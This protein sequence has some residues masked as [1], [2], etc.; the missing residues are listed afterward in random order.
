VSRNNLAMH[1]GQMEVYKHP[2]RFKCVV[3]GRRW[4][5]SILS[6]NM[7]IK[8][9]KIPRRK[10]W[11]VAPTY[12]M[13]QQIMWQ[14][15]LDAVPD[16]WVKK[17]NHTS[18]TI[19]LINGSVIE[20]KGADNPDSLRGVGIHFLVLDEYQDMSEDTWKKALR[21]TL[22]DTG[23]DAL[24]IGTPKSYNLLYD[25]Y[26]LGQDP[27]RQEGPRS[28][29]WMSWQYPTITS[30]F[31]PKE[32]VDAAREDMDK[33]SFQQEF[34][35]CHLPDTK[36]KLFDGG[37]KRVS[38]VTK[39]DV[40]C[41]LTNKGEVMP[42]EVEDSGLTGFRTIADAVLETGEVVSASNNHKFKVSVNERC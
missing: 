5:K 30:P 38:A 39:G 25:V 27:V 34:M 26:M 22:A 12:R 32:E 6:R 7:I 36:V 28:R 19:W 2:A 33:K 40:L 20:L 23:G 8:Y 41:H 11:Y 42:C 3:A 9:A 16:R 15:M 18:L 37:E 24:F 13:A 31:I 4:G 29:S 17:I 1:S 10:V 35:A 14:V 21:P